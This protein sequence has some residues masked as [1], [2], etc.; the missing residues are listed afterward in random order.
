[1]KRVLLT[2]ASGFIGSACIAELKARGYE[3]HAV[4]NQR[5]RPQPDVTEHICDLLTD[6]IRAL[7]ENVRPSH[8]LHLAWYAVPGLY[9]TSRENLQWVRA[10]LA[11]YEAFLQNG[12]SRA[13]FAGTAAEYDWTFGTCREGDTPLAPTTTYGICKRALGDVLLT[14]ARISTSSIAWARY[15]FLYG[16][17]EYPQRLVPSVTRAL[18][19]DEVARCSEGTQ[20]R[21]FMHVADAAAATIA[22]LDCAVTG[23]VNIASGV[24]L[25][26]RALVERIAALVGAGSVEF[27]SPVNEPPRVVADVNR[28]ASEVGYVSH[29]TLDD[30]LNQTVQWWREHLT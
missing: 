26:V 5:S 11:L 6:D 18:L 27:G 7:L 22:L 24:A 19:R 14:E 29:Y 8:L 13:V 3:I 25:R 16:P 28:L 2:G 9:W 1:M 20:E 12:G 21:D 15:F 4:C 10:S 17:N 30:R 23:P